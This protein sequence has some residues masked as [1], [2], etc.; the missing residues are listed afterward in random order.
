MAGHR[1]HRAPLRSR[2]RSPGSGVGGPD[3]AAALSR[4]LP[5]APSACP[6]WARS[7]P[8]AAGRRGLPSSA[9]ATSV[10][11]A[12]SPRC[13]T[14]RA[15][16]NAVTRKRAPWRSNVQ[17]PPRRDRPHLL[18]LHWP[19]ARLPGGGGGGRC[20]CPGRLAPD[21][22]PAAEAHGAIWVRDPAV[23]QNRI[24]LGGTELSLK[25]AHGRR[26][27]LGA[28][29][30]RKRHRGASVPSP[31]LVKSRA[32]ARFSSL[33]R[34]RRPSRRRSSAWAGRHPARPARAR[35]SARHPSAEL[36]RPALDRGARRCGRLSA[37]RLR[38][39]G[40]GGRSPS[41]TSAP[42]AASSARCRAGR[43]ARARVAGGH[44]ARA[45]RAGSPCPGARP[46]PRGSSP[47]GQARKPPQQQGRGPASERD[48]SAPVAFPASWRAR[49]RRRLRAL[50]PS[51]APPSGA[52]AADGGITNR[53]YRVRFAAGTTSCASR[54]RTPTCSA[55]TAMPSARRRG[56]GG[57][58]VAPEVLAYLAEPRL[59]TAFIEARRAGRGW[60]RAA[61]RW[62][63]RCGDP[64]AARRCRRASRFPLDAQLRGDARERGGA[65][66]AGL[67]E[68]RAIAARSSGARLQPRALPQRP[69]HR[70]LPPRRRRGCDRRL[71]VRRD[72]RPLLRPRRTSRSTTAC[73]TP[74]TEELLAAYFGEP[75]PAP[76]RAPAAD[77][78][79]V[80]LPGGDV[81]RRPAGDSPTLD[82]DYVGYADEHF[83]RGP[84]PRSTTR[85]STRGSRHAAERPTA[86]AVVI[87][88][89]GVGGD[90]DRVPPGRA[91]LSATCCSSTA[92]S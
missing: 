29:A 89:G 12:R 22:V 3:R 61:R 85:D 73:P 40:P 68:V 91:R 66:P 74:T 86:R 50:E 20:P 14:G 28:L 88:G 38:R 43:R 71:G 56:G 45:G 31:M 34:R 30:C 25:R 26:R 1:L 15:S 44:R 5:R 35:S 67:P 87:I 52:R 18:L 13:G 83:A 90:V 55:S 64:R 27:S 7:S 2:R 84:R 47:S 53:N 63:R 17:D 41:A 42:A 75:T 21:A 4:G 10:L 57:V 9:S 37:S 23:E 32:V 36:R 82:F 69:A 51:S 48:A 79:H 72:G 59:V 39:A 8:A 49:D 33:S 80:R 92:A 81:G 24:R 54:A 62:R 65:I 58:G 46:S 77:A 6:G 19:R 78:A 11:R 76:T 16:I 60:Q 70:E